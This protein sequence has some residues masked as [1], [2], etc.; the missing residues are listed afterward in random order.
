MC[1]AYTYVLMLGYG[2]E[3]RKGGVIFTKHSEASLIFSFSA[4]KPERN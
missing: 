2:E 1:F 3:E 4:E